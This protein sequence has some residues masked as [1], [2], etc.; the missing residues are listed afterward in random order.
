MKRTMVSIMVWLCMC[1]WTAAA[2]SAGV[3]AMGIFAVLPDLQPTLSDYTALPV[4]SQGRLAA[5]LITEPIFTATDLAQAACSLL[6]LLGVILHRML[7]MGS[8]R[9]A[10]Y[11]VW[12][13]SI[14]AACALL[15]GRLLLMMPKMNRMLQG[16]RDAAMDGDLDRALVAKKAFD[17][18]HPAAASMMEGCVA[19]LMI[20]IVA[21]AVV[22][23]FTFIELFI[24]QL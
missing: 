17:A 15:W 22:A 1:L 19:F 18:L 7:G 12:L 16:Y 4:E 2:I 20:A 24:G 13:L 3:S 21:G 10:A 6:L 11:V 9:P 23:K 5:G 14:A 8:H